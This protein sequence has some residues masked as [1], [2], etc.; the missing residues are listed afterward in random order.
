MEAISTLPDRF[1]WRRM[2]SIGQLYKKSIRNYLILSAV[3]SLA[4]YLLTRVFS[5]IGGNTFTVYMI[6]STILAAVFYLNPLTFSRR[7]DT[8]M[9]LLPAKPIEKWTFYIIYCM[10]IVPCVIQGIWYGADFCYSAI[11]SVPTLQ[12]SIIDYYKPQIP[13][14]KCSDWRLMLISASQAETLIIL[15]LYVTLRCRRHRV[16]KGLLAILGYLFFIG[17]VSGISGAL[18]AISNLS[19]AI[20]DLTVE[21]PTEVITVLR[22]LLIVI[23]SIISLTAILGLWLSYRCIAKGEVKN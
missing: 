4:C 19:P 16:I 20:N 5:S 12:D 15:V 21:D 1:S 3:L 22:P 23:Y 17:I 7:D 9:A 6:M 11:N 8:L 14:L 13:N 2:A 18:I 10:L